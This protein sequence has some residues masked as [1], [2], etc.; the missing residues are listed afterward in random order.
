MQLTE[1][2]EQ[3]WQ[4][5]LSITAKLMGL[6]FVV[7]FVVTFFARDLSFNFFGWPFSFWMA[8]QGS[9]IIYVL[10]IWYYASYMNK[11]DQEHGVA[12]EEGE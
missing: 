3:Y 10:I 2:Q 5:N 1:L 8:S 9:L 6:W 7:T 12:E 4:K 11:I